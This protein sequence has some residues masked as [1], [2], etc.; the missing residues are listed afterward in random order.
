VIN[1]FSTSDII[2]LYDLSIGLW[3]CSD[4]VV[5][6]CFFRSANIDCQSIRSYIKNTEIDNAFARQPYNMMEMFGKQWKSVIA[7]R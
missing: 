6:C 1:S 4:G 2:C 3:N 5:F 7:Y